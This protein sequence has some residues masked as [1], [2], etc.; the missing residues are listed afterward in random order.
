MI[1]IEE[2]QAGSDGGQAGLAGRT[3]E[4]P[5]QRPPQLAASFILNRA[6]VVTDGQI[7][8]TRGASGHAAAG[9]SKLGQCGGSEVLFMVAASS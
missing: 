9:L 2:F 3:A 1:P 8:P 5:Q 7:A 4:N 6:P